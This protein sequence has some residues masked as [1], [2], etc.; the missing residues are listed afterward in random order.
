MNYYAARQHIETKT[1]C[2]TYMNDGVIYTDSCCL[3]HDITGHATKEE[4]ER[5]YYDHQIAGLHEVKYDSYNK[6]QIKGCGKLTNI[7]LSPKHS[8]SSTNLCKSHR[9]KESYMEV[10]PFNTGITIISS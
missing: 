9:N 3:N 10:N 8:Y 6:C 7:A 1:W 4:A 5:C 2:F